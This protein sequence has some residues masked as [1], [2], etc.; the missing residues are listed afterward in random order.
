MHF[1][2]TYLYRNRA[3][4]VLRY[5]FGS[6]YLRKASIILVCEIILLVNNNRGIT[7]CH[8]FSFEKQVKFMNQFKHIYSNNTH[9]Y[10]VKHN[11]NNLGFERKLRAYLVL[12]LSL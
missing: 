8:I 10:T 11:T 3:I 12:L 7:S 6:V 1:R 9:I 5:K 2:T 4:Y